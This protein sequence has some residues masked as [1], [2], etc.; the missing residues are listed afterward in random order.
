V[1]DDT[2]P[3]SIVIVVPINTYHGHAIFEKVVSI[4]VMDGRMG[5]SGFAKTM[6][7]I[8]KIATAMPSI[9]SRW[10]ARRHRIPRKNPPRS[11]P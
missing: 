2:I 7:D 3:T 8:T 4:P 11:A 1:N 9:A 6:N 5:S 10:I